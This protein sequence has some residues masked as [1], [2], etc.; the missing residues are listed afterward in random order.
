MFLYV[1]SEGRGEV[2]REK[3]DVSVSRLVGG[4]ASRGSQGAPRGHSWWSGPWGAGPLS[5]VG[6]LPRPGRVA[7]RSLTEKLAEQH[8]RALGWADARSLRPALAGGRRVCLR[9]GLAAPHLVQG[10]R[11]ALQREPTPG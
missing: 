5:D 4:P 8:G 9:R 1:R 2:E 10:M 6:P 3:D 11:N 7:T